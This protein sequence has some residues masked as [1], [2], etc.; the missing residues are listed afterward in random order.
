MNYK[1]KLFYSYSHKDESFRNELERWLTNLNKE[2]LIN[3]WHDR[4]I[5]AGL[6]WEESIDKNLEN[7][8]IFLSLI[9]QNYLASAA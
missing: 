9:S 7:S 3:E 8:D 4:K 5:S 2:G 6:D 1:L